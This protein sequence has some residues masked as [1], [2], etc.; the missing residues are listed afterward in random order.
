[1][2]DRADLLACLLIFKRRDKSMSQAQM[3]S[4]TEAQI[5]SRLRLYR[6]LFLISILGNLI[7]CLWCIFD[8][9]GFARLLSQPDPYPQSWPRV[10]GATLLGLHLVYVPGLCNPLF[11]RW[12]N[13]SSI[14]I[15]FFMPIIFV[16]SGRYFYPFAV[17]DFSFGVILL[18]AYYR[19][20]VAHATGNP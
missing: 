18:V 17:W 2:A 15:K 16:S 14:A 12:P 11:Y 4:R 7:V 6:V 20:T 10:W 9:V 8:P 5:A 1:M 19:L 13:W 3:L